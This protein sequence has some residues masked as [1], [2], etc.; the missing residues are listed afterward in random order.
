MR[1]Q[2]DQTR[3]EDMIVKSSVLARSKTRRYPLLWQEVDDP[4]RGNHYRMVFENDASGFDRNN[5]SSVNHQV[6]GGHGNSPV[7]VGS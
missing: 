3:D 7:L 6:N 5:P 4:T 2:V 1:V